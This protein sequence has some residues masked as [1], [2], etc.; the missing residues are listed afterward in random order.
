[1]DRIGAIC[2]LLLAVGCGDGAAATDAGNAAT[3]ARGTDSTPAVDAAASY[4]APGYDAAGYDAVS[5][6]AVSYD[7]V[8][9]DAAPQCPPAMYAAYF[10]T[11]SDVRAATF[12]SLD[13][14]GQ[15]QL[16]SYLEELESTGAIVIDEPSASATCS[17]PDSCTYI[18]PTTGERAQIIAAKY[19]HAIWIDH[20][21]SVPWPLSSYTPAELAGLFDPNVIF[22]NGSHFMS[23]VDFS[24]SEAWAYVVEQDLVGTTVDETLVAIIADLRT[25]DTDIDFLHGI[26]GLGDPVNTAYT[27]DE[28]LRT[29]VDRGNTGTFARISRRGCHSMSRVM[30]ALAR[31]MNIPGA[32]V[33][34]GQWFGNGHSTPTWGVASSVIPHGD[35]LYGATQRVTPSAEMLTPMSFY[36]ESSN[37]DV[38]GADAFCLGNRHAALNAMAYPANYTTAR[39]CNPATYS[40]ASCNDYL[41]TNYA[42]TLTAG[43]IATAEATLLATCSP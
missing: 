10:A 17:E 33:H 7:A 22:R 24:P 28:A 35:D 37:T 12:D 42:T 14:A 1:V 15:A 5:Y 27:L 21:D 16:C 3:D 8:S 18:T 31:S 38:C 29:W 19:A 6:D 9:Y 25:T 4:D 40:Y 39:C 34:A 20:H 30:L 11:N 43:E 23:V 2:A 41:T 13:V 26:E 36:T 32:E